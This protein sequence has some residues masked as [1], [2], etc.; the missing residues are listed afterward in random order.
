MF[1]QGFAL[2]RALRTLFTGLVSRDFATS[3]R[4]PRFAVHTHLAALLET[5]F[6][7][8]TRFLEVDLSS[9]RTLVRRRC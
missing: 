3:V 9:A 4:N 6:A 1:T 7:A 5:L 8:A 2:V